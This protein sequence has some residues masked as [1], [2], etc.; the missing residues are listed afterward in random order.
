[1]DGTF[2]EGSFAAHQ[3]PLTGV[4]SNDK[5]FS[6]LKEWLESYSVH[7]LISK[8]GIPTD[9]V[10]SVIP[11]DDNLKMGMRKETYDCYQPLDLPPWSENAV[12]KEKQISCMEVTG[13][14]LLK[15]IG[16][17]DLGF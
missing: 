6:L 15:V 3:V 13:K 5:Q 12:E 2:I 7:D 4:T 10:L 1:M 8:D 9:E 17:Y 11:T 16:R 14:Y